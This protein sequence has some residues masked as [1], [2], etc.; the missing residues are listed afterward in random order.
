M[1]KLIIIAGCL[2]LALVLGLTLTWPKYQDLRI[3]QMD[4]KDKEAKLQSQKEYF[5]QIKEISE[6]LEEYIEP[7]AKISS[8]LPKTPSLPSLFNFLQ[9][10]ASQTGLLL[11][12]MTLG[13]V[14]EGEIR[15]SNKLIGDY[16][17]FKNFLLAL[18]TSSRMIEVESIA[19]ESPKEP[20]EP[21]EPFTFVVKI[22][23]HSY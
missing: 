18:E 1:N 5:S 17:A 3:L 6:Q 14:S 13:G 20:D 22:K 16:P 12:E 9:L 23:T 19:F 21:D 11:E 4:I 2:V 7:L 15:V 8:A 10:S